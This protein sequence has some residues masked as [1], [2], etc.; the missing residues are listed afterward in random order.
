[1]GNFY[2]NVTLVDVDADDV[3][4]EVPR[5]SFVVFDGAHAVVF[6]AEDD[7]GAPLAGAGLTATLRCAGISIG[8]HDDDVLFWE[9]HRRGETVAAGAVP[10]P[11]E[12]FGIDLTPQ[13]ALDDGLDLDDE[14]DDEDEVDL[15]GDLVLALGRGDV[16]AVR[17]ALATDRVFATDRHIALVEALGLPRAA[18]GWGHRYLAADW[19]EHDLTRRL[20]GLERFDA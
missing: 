17:E 11:A 14:D 18:V 12:Y 16:E 10:H 3:R 1:M 7:A 9:V 5:P 6:A 4:R 8:V 2:L 15:A 19:G 13:H 20:P